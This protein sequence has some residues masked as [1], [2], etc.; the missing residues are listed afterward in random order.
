MPIQHSDLDMPACVTNGSCAGEAVCQNP[1][2]GRS[3]LPGYLLLQGTD[4]FP[5]EFL[6]MFIQ[7]HQRPVRF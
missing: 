1:A 3:R 5:E 2:I 7:A 6:I 4:H